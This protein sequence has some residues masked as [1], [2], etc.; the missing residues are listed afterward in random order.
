M[1]SD[2][3]EKLEELLQAENSQEVSRRLRV[4]CTLG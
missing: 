3:V 2:K 1:W 4:C